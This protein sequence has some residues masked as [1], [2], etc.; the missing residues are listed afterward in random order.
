VSTKTNLLRSVVEGTPEFDALLATLKRR[1]ESDLGRV[2][3]AVREILD[4]VRREGDAAL[5][6]YVERFEQRRPVRFLV[7]DYGGAAALASLSE[8]VREALEIA[9]ARIRRYHARQAEGLFGFEYEENGVRLGSRVRPLERVGVYA[10]GGKARYPSSVL[11]A[12][13]PA[14]VAGVKEIIVASPDT[15]P[16]VRAACHLAGVHALLDAGGAQAVA[17]LAYGTESVPRVDK[18]VGPGNVYVAAA[19]RLVFG[20]VS[21]DSIAGPSE[22]LVVADETADAR[23]VAADLLSQAEHDEAAYPLL[24]TTSATLVVAVERELA[25]QLETQPRRTIAEASLRGNG[26]ALVVGSR[27]QLAAI[28]NALAAEHVAVQT[29]EPAALANA[30]DVAGALFVG[31][32]TPEAAGDYLAGPS[33]VL[34]TG[35]A[36]RH[37]SPLGVYDFVARS[38]IIEYTREALAAQAGPI[39]AFARAEGLE[40]HARAVEVRTL[41]PR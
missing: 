33:H 39:A 19:K 15:S 4:A 18:I 29:R 6:R 16:E 5:A 13:I 30:I 26:A 32:S 17:A 38:S 8:D 28:A 7:R 31:A 34:P 25:A 37:A 35:G 24:V 20:E 22:I 9:A 10:P 2:E 14:A 40:A 11:M 12:V 36:A 23:V 3:P 21:I 27:E 41:K 1:G